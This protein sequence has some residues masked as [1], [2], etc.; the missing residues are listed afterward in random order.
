M[1]TFILVERVDKLSNITA[2]LSNKVN[3]ISVNKSSQCNVPNERY[4]LTMDPMI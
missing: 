2:L 4:P 1:S 3:D